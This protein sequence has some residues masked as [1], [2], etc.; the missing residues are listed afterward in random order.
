[1]GNKW[2]AAL[3]E[4]KEKHNTPAVLREASPGRSE[5]PD[6]PQP[7]PSETSKTPLGFQDRLERLRK[8][9]RARQNP[10]SKTSDTPTDLSRLVQQKLEKASRMGLVA[11]WSQH[12]GYVSVH[13]PTTGEWHDLRTEDAPGWAVREARRRKTRL[14]RKGGGA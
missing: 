11:T 13:D 4:A 10:P 2:L 3:I 9:L 5:N 1:M 14:A 12:H 7:S 6:T 8:K